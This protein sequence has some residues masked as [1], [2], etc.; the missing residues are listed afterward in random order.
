MLHE[1]AVDALGQITALLDIVQQQPED[2]I[3]TLLVGAQIGAH[4]RHVHDHFSAFF[5][6]CECGT[7]DYNRRTRNSP[8]ET[9]LGVCLCQHGRILETLKNHASNRSDLRIISE[10]DCRTSRN[11]ELD[12]TIDRELL[13]L[14]NHTIHHVALISLKLTHYGIA[15]PPQLGL[16]PGTASY[17]RS[18]D[19]SKAA[20][21]R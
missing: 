21:G 1:A 7:L 17:R 10:I 19:P 12:S 11:V 5:H 15:V 16:A 9:E 20:A 8:A 2:A 14:I 13:Y 3:E 18:R 6:G 4:I